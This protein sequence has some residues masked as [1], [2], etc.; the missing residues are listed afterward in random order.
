MANFGVVVQAHVQLDNINGLCW[1]HYVRAAVTRNGL[2]QRHLKVNFSLILCEGNNYY[3]LIHNS[4]KH[5]LL[6]WLHTNYF[7]HLRRPGCLF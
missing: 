2:K 7:K 4:A 3:S 5:T 6:P 1:L